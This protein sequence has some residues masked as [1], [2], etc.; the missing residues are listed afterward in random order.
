MKPKKLSNRNERLSHV[1]RLTFLIFCLCLLGCENDPDIVNQKND[2]KPNLE[3]AY[4]I[5]SFLSQNGNLRAKLTSPFMLRYAMD[6]SYL[7]FPK[8]LHV[9]FFDSTGKVESQVDALYGKYFETRNKVYLR[10]SVVVFNVKG[11]TLRSPDLWWDQNTKKFYTDNFIRL[12]TKDKR[13]YGGKGFEAD[14]DL[15][16]WTIFQPTG[17]I[18]VP[19]SM[20]VQ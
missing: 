13:L 16:R 20:K 8:T 14:Q 4:N 5:Q 11:D 6:T 2:R 19:D 1:S 10:D 7:E 3:E 12:R 15:N 18:Y 17:I 9:N